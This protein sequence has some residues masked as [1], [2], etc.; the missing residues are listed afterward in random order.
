VHA[1]GD[2]R[3]IGVEAHGDSVGSRKRGWARSVLET[4]G[5]RAVVVLACDEHRSV[6]GFEGPAVVE[7]ITVGRRVKRKETR[8]GRGPRRTVGSPGSLWHGRRRRGSNEVDGINE[9]LRR[10]EKRSGDRALDWR[11]FRSILR[12]SRRAVT[13]RIERRPWFI[14]RRPVAAGRR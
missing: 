8:R 4:K 13:R 5:S 3:R 10:P 12:A 7:E 11:R 1:G 2:H 9:N 14:E 6:V